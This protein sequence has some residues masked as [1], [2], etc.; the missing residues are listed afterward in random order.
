M[1]GIFE[2]RRLIAMVPDHN[3]GYDPSGLKV[4]CVKA[5]FFKTM[6]SFL[7]DEKRMDGENSD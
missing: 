6:K 2:S 5:A 3:T 7:F 1:G 4:F